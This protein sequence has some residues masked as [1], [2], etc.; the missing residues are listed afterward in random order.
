MH[1]H[2]HR[3]A[4]HEGP[5]IPHYFVDQLGKAIP[6]DTCV[7]TGASGTCYTT[8]HQVDTDKRNKVTD[9]AQ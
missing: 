5:V 8:V 7:V 6:D 9:K 4:A 1:A 3:Y 2:V